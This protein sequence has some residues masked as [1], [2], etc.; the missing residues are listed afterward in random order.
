[1]KCGARLRGMERKMMSNSGR[2]LCFIACLSYGTVA[3]SA[4]TPPS[5]PVTA[6]LVVQIGDVT[7]NPSSLVGGT[8][9]VVG[10]V[11]LLRAAPA[12]GVTVSFHSSNH[13]V[14][15]VPA[16]VVVQ[17]GATSATFVVQTHPVGWNLK[18]VTD[19]RPVEIAAQI[20]TSAPKTAK[21]T[22]LPPALTSLTISPPNS[23]G[24][25]GWTGQ[26]TINGPAP[27]GG[28]FVTL[29][30]KATIT[31]VASAP[32]HVPL[33]VANAT[34]SQG[35]GEVS[36]PA[37]VTIGPGATTVS[38]PIATKPVSAPR[39]FQ[40]NASSGPSGINTTMTLLPPSLAALLFTWQLKP[41]QYD[42]L[43][44][45]GGMSLTGKLT[46]TGPTPPEGITVQLHMS[47]SIDTTCKPAP[48]VQA[49]VH[50]YGASAAY[51][52]RPSVTFPIS[53]F[54]VSR[55][56]D[57]TLKATYGTSVLSRPFTVDIPVPVSLT[58][59]PPSVQG[60][61]SVQGTIVL[62]GP[63]LP[64]ACNN[65]QP[66][67]YNLWSPNGSSQSGRPIFATF[68]PS[69]VIDP[70]K[71]A[72]TFSLKTSAVTSTMNIAIN[73]TVDSS[74]VIQYETHAN[75]VTGGLTI[76]P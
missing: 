74:L 76:T 46:L 12:G 71:T 57:F 30:S 73:A 41:D 64:L 36:I 14:A 20:G 45:P 26:V 49:T 25:T 13:A 35:S 56:T 53:T 67:K 37:E 40:V 69:V 32:V 29:S 44:A 58:F 9:P 75:T 28:F 22:V 31:S 62:S 17:P 47:D 52:E 61:G 2:L 38:F 24:G 1:M 66:F 23:P 39:T 11:T 5:V 70:G 27:S 48:T 33:D 54:P 60:G 50:V 59:S 15:A 68:P 18:V 4:T 55:P 51:N 21:L 6:K 72:A 65:N 43:Y 19:L 42:P 8:A 63:V 7:L 10:T 34:A 16:N 3:A